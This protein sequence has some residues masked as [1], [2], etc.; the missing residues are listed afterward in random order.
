MEAPAPAPAL[1]T[2]ADTETVVA[3]HAPLVDTITTPPAPTTALAVDTPVLAPATTTAPPALATVPAPMVAP[4]A[5]LVPTTTAPPAPAPAPAPAP[6]PVS[7]PPAPINTAEITSHSS[8]PAGGVDSKPTDTPAPVPSSSTTAIAGSSS[9]QGSQDEPQSSLTKK[10]TVDEWKA[11]VEF[12]VC[13]F[14]LPKCAQY[15]GACY[16]R[17]NC[18]PYSQPR[19][20]TSKSPKLNPRRLLS[21][22]SV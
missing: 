14:K 2:V 6:T 13:V 4:D 8:A 7:N 22:G 21:G 18:P 19:S 12:R 20:L 10:F 16:C 15:S 3:P 17:M 11:L 1:S 9:V 5:T